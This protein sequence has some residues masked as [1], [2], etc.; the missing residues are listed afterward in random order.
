MAPAAQ[1][2]VGPCLGTRGPS[3]R[4][5]PRWAPGGEEAV[6]PSLTS[7]PPFPPESSALGSRWTGKPGWDVEPPSPPQPAKALLSQVPVSPDGE[8]APL[9]P[10]MGGPLHPLMGRSLYPLT[11]GSLHP[12]GRRSLHP[13]MRSCLHPLLGWGCPCTPLGRGSLYPV[14]GAGGGCIP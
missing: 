5:A 7:Y 9:Y 13:L 3:S 6:A 4:L 1:D 8:G 2:G 14:S 11:A 10:L 12:L